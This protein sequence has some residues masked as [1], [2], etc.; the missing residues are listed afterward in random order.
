MCLLY[1]YFTFKFVIIY[2]PLNLP[3]NYV[4]PDFCSVPKNRVRCHTSGL[5]RTMAVVE[6]VVEGAEGGGLAVAATHR[7]DAVLPLTPQFGEASPVHAQGQGHAP[8]TDVLLVPVICLPR[9]R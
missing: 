5:R 7:G 3:F 9:R 4:C 2:I 6:V 8:T 1:N